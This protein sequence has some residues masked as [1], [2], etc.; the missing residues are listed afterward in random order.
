MKETSFN[1]SETTEESMKQKTAHMHL[2]QLKT[3]NE[4]EYM[5]TFSMCF[6]DQG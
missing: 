4:A 5:E 3:G 2:V 1:I 6:L